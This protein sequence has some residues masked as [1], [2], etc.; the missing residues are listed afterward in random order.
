[1]TLITS[2]FR[3]SVGFLKSNWGLF[4]LYQGGW[5]ACAYSELLG[6]PWLGP[7]AMAGFLWV[8]CLNNSPRTILSL[9]MVGGLIGMTLDS[10][11]VWGQVLQF[12]RMQQPG[13]WSPYLGLAPLWMVAL[14]S[15]FA[16]LLE[17]SLRWMRGRYLLSVVFGAVGGP[18]AYAAGE[19][20]GALTLLSTSSPGLAPPL[21]WV[22]L[23][24]AVAMPLLL[25]TADRLTDPGTQP[26]PQ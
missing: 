9:A 3:L 24:W 12:H 10:L 5:F 2:I 8:M 22:A 16:T 7:A 26:P 25:W 11:L 20:M 15:G 21:L 1:M 23:E 18:F 19:R 4:L 17:T 13:S 14:W 6:V